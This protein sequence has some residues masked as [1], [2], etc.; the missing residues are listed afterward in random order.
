M[1][2][3]IKSKPLASTKA[4]FRT[5]LNYIKC[6]EKL[7]FSSNL[8]AQKHGTPTKR[9][10][11]IKRFQKLYNVTLKSIKKDVELAKEDPEFAVIIAPWFPVKCYYAIYYLES[12]LLH[13]ID[14]CTYGFSKGGHTGVK[15]KIYSLMNSNISFNQ[16]DLDTV[17]NLTRVQSMSSINIGRNARNDYWQKQECIQSVAKILMRYKLH[18]AKTGRKWN[19]HTKKHQTE[20]QQFISTERLALIDFFYWYRIKAN[21]RDLDYI[22]FENGITANEVLEYVETY[23]SAFDIYR[24]SLVK[25]INLLIK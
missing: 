20:K 6:I 5:H 18:D 16:T 11:E 8:T 23:Y 19:L 1:S 22:D 25:Q 17:Y 14:G 21:Y 10:T 12:V 7:L 15:K 3:I 13:L 24:A 9:K 2:I 4:S